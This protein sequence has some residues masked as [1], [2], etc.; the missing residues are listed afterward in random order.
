MSAPEHMRAALDIVWQCR[1]TC[2]ETLYAHCLTMGGP[3]VAAAHVKAMTDCIEAC[4]V[5]AD[6]MTR[7]SALHGVQCAA[8]AEVCDACAKSCAAIESPQMQA[9]ADL[10]RRCAKT[11]R[12]MSRA[13]VAA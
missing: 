9:C 6:F 12:D 13:P 3:H 11:C 10:C 2:M 8:C 7:N 1:T 5:C 4:Q